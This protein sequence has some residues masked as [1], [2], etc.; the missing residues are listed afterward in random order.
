MRFRI[1]L[2]GSAFNRLEY[3]IFTTGD[4]ITLTRG[5]RYQQVH[6]II[7]HNT[8]FLHVTVESRVHYGRDG[9][10]TD[11]GLVPS[12]TATK[13]GVSVEFGEGDSIWKYGISF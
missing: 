7:A 6:E 5:T 3:P 4:T 12:G 13:E 1:N 9:F 10:M 2:S 8:H 11:A